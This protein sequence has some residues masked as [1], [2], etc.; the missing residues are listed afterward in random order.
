[1]N[2]WKSKWI[3]DQK[4]YDPYIQIL[5]NYIRTRFNHK[6]HWCGSAFSL[7]S[8]VILLI[9]FRRN[10]FKLAS[11]TL[12]MLIFYTLI[13]KT[14]LSSHSH[15]TMRLPSYPLPIFMIK[16]YILWTDNWLSHKSVSSTSVRSASFFYLYFHL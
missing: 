1:M 2:T 7:N 9:L 4:N 3:K 16:N 14:N 10:I 8:Y 13:I 11:Q 5:V 6:L 12:Y 15:I